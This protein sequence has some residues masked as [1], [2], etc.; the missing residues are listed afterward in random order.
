MWANIVMNEKSNSWIWDPSGEA[1]EL[2]ALLVALMYEHVKMARGQPHWTQIWGINLDQFVIVID[3]FR[4][5]SFVILLI[6]G[7]SFCQTNKQTDRHQQFYR[8]RWWRSKCTSNNKNLYCFDVR[9]HFRGDY[10]D[11]VNKEYRSL[12][13]PDQVLTISRFFFDSIYC[14]LWIYID[15]SS[16]DLVPLST[17]LVYVMVNPALPTLC[18][19]I[20]DQNNW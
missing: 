3:I 13:T 14:R 18:H 15:W 7:R 2:P 20:L 6:S 4:M 10:S 16:Q 19:P 17:R 11:T 1:F 5:Q 9:S 12:F 8:C